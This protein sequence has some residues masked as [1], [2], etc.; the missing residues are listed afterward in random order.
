[1]TDATNVTPKIL[2]EQIKDFNWTVDEILEGAPAY[3]KKLTDKKAVKES[4]EMSIQDV[5][6][7]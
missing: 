6:E 4:Y 7:N 2:M 5:P 1:M 3:E